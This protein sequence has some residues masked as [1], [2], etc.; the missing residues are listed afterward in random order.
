MFYIIEK[1]NREMDEMKRMLS[2]LIKKMATS[3]EEPSSLPER[4]QFPLASEEAVQALE[5]N[6]ADNE[7]EKALVSLRHCTSISFFLLWQTYLSFTN[8]QVK[9]SKT[10]NVELYQKDQ[11]NEKH[12]A[13]S[14]PSPP[15]ALTTSVPLADRTVEMWNV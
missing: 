4:I 3:R 2:S 7:T 10:K 14:P 15:E 12:I 11:Y 5:Q 13:C 1:Q 6:L 8:E 9:G